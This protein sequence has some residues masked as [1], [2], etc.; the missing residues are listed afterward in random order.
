[1][2]EF[3]LVQSDMRPEEVWLQEPEQL[4]SETK[5]LQSCLFYFKL[6]ELKFGNA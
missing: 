4:S 6:L 3:V 2:W 5:K 1:M